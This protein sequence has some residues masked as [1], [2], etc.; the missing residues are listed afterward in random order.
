M[1]IHTATVWQ[2]LKPEDSAMYTGSPLTTYFYQP[3]SASQRL[4]CLQ[5]QVL[6]WEPRTQTF[7]LLLSIQI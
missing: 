4:Q 3:G 2:G 6:S 7:D 5:N 1:S